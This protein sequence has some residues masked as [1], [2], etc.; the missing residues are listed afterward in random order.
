MRGAALGAL[1]VLALGAGACSDDPAEVDAAKDRQLEQL[2][3]SVP[4]SLDGLRVDEEDITETVEQGSRPYL[5]AVALYSFREEDDLLQATLQVGRFAGD[6]DA[7]DEEFRDLIINNIGTGARELRM[8]DHTVFVTG[9]DRQTLS[10]W[11]QGDHLFILS[12]RDGFEGGRGLL[13]AALE[14]Q[15]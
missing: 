11:F 13:R 2:D 10:V 14:V 6:V 7:E 15:P 5:D 4:L 12:T 1:L 3:I 9:A 8:G